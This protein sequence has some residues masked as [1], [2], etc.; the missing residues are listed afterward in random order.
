MKK[1]PALDV[2]SAITEENDD[3][4][5]QFPSWEHWAQD[6]DGADETWMNHE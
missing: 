2:P 1:S 4:D 6:T 5:Q 3:D